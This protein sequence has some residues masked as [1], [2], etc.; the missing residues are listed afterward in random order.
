MY[1]LTNTRT[2]NVMPI[3]FLF[4]FSPLTRSFHLTYLL[5]LL[6]TFFKIHFTLSFSTQFYFYYRCFCSISMDQFISDAKFT[7]TLDHRFF[8]NLG[9]ST[10]TSTTKSPFLPDS[11]DMFLLQSQ[12]LKLYFFTPNISEE[13]TLM[14]SPFQNTSFYLVFPYSYALLITYSFNSSY[15]PV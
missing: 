4:P 2:Y 3:I 6:I 12:V 13:V 11:T 15:I 5:S 9:R 1:L 14:H 8:T 10:L 7:C